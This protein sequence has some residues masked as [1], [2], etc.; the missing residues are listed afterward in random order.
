MVLNHSR[1]ELVIA[2]CRGAKNISDDTYLGHSQEDHDKNLDEVLKRIQESGLKINLEK[3]I[4]SGNQL[5]F[6][7]RTLSDKG[8]TP[9]ASK[10]EAILKID[11]QQLNGVFLT[12][13]II[14]LPVIKLF[15][16]FTAVLLLGFMNFVIFVLFVL[17]NFLVTMILYCKYFLYGYISFFLY[18]ILLIFLYSYIS[19]FLIFYIVNIPSFFSSYLFKHDPN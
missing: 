10:V 11:A 12:F 6:S 16:I 1:K 19:F 13:L 2:G 9:D 8:V 17:R 5:I 18:F 14:I 15:L 4:F 3:C 7:G